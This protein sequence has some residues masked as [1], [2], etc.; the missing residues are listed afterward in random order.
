MSSQSQQGGPPGEQPD[1]NKDSN[2]EDESQ[3]DST[4]GVQTRAMT[5]ASGTEPSSDIG[6]PRIAIE[7][8]PKAAPKVLAAPPSYA[9]PLGVPLA[10]LGR[11]HF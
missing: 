11:E 10:Q 6:I 4:T 7:Y 1:K 9:A 5:R 8:Q 3:R 2:V